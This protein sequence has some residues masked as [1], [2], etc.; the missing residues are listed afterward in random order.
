MDFKQLT[1]D[2][3]AEIASTTQTGSYAQVLRDF[4]AA[5][6]DG[7]DLTDSFP[8]KKL[9]TVAAGLKNAQRKNADFASVRVVHMTR[10]GVEVLALVKTA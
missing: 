2:Q 7:A 1:P 5:G 6:I 10:D 4:L 8:G 9:T 3:I